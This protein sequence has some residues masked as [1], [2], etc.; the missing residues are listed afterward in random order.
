MTKCHACGT[1]MLGP[2]R[3]CRNCG[4]PAAVLIEDFAETREFDPVDTSGAAANTTLHASNGQFYA[5]ASNTYPL[6]LGSDASFQTASLIAGLQNFAR[7][8]LVWLLAFL[9]LLVFIP[10]GLA[11]GR[12]V[13]RSRR[14]QRAEQARD[15]ELARQRKQTKQ[16]ETA[17][18]SFEETVQNALGFKPADVSAAEYPDLHG[19]FVASL[20]SE[21]SPA[22]LAHIQAGRCVD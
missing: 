10:S 14:A 22:A 15:A 16:A 7:R 6:P 9:L 8:K 5:P 21:Y 2:E 13:I 11:V 17:R 4:A 20:T 3:F 19:I 1:E 12:N 18:R